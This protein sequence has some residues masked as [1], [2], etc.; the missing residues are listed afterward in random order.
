M[1]T[2]RIMIA[3]QSSG[4]GKTT[5]SCGI[6]Q[7]LV[8][9]GLKVSSFKCGPDYIDPMFHKKVIGADS[10]NVDPFFSDDEQLKYLFSRSADRT[11]IAVI[12]GVM[13]FYDGSSLD[14]SKD[15]SCDI[16]LKLDAPVILIVDSSGSS[17]S[18]LAVLKGFADLE[19]NNI[20]G[21]IFNRMSERVFDSIRHH[22]IDMGITP[23]GYIP[24]MKDIK[25]ESRHLGLVMPDEISDIKAMLNEVANRFERTL[26]ID[27]L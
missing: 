15:S 18:A 3:A 12:E 16:S 6:L 8:N 23:I 13:G 9:R 27:L 25:L 10:T 2:P 4:S 7:A 21:V 24:K 20:K 19:R 14:S 17:Y 11:D 1:T 5:I 26:D 22:V